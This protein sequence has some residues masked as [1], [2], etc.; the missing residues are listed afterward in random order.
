ML[1]NERARAESFGSDAERYERARPRYPSALLDALVTPETHDVL[2]VGCGTG[3]ASR[4][5]MERGCTVLGVEVDER[6]ASVARSFG[7]EVEVGHFETWSPAGRTFDLVAS[8]QA[9]HWVDPELGPARAAAA[10]RPHGRIALF[11][12]FRRSFGGAGDR[13]IAD[14]YQRLAPSLAA[15][16]LSGSF[17]RL[18]GSGE[19]ATAL[20]RS[21]LFD[22]VKVSHLSWKQHY[23]GD[24][25]LDLVGTHSD[26]RLL[27]PQA[28]AALLDALTTTIDSLGGVLD[29]EYETVCVLGDLRSQ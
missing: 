18:E 2:D 10:L 24:E 27:D 6:M 15:S 5:F 22:D 17:E 26:H 16:P 4:G 13:A 20:E 19:H 28:L 25:W 21:E 14:C 12:N 8:G 11:W 3:K 23:T 7:V 1:H 29:V 9:W